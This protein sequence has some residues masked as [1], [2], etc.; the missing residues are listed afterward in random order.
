LDKGRT[1]V[2]MNE[3]SSYSLST[4]VTM[5]LAMQ[6]AFASAQKVAPAQT[7]VRHFH[8]AGLSLQINFVGT[9][10]AEKFTRSFVHLQVEAADAKAAALQI[11]LWDITASCVSEPSIDLA[12]AFPDR[13][14]FA[15]GELSAVDDSRYS[16]HCSRHST[17]LL[18]AESGR[19]A[20]FVQSAD[21]LSLYEVGKPLQPLLFAWYRRNGRQPVHA[22]C[23][24]RGSQGVLIGGAGGS[25]K[26]TTSLACTMA[27]FQFLADD[28]VA[29]AERGDE[30]IAYSLYA[31]LWLEDQH[32]RQFTSLSEH[33]MQVPWQTRLKIPFALG[34]AYPQQMVSSCV[35][36]ALVLPRVTPGE[37]S[38]LSRATP[39]EALLKMAP[40]SVVQLPFIDPVE[41]LRRMAELV[42]TVPAFWLDAGTDLA[43]IPD[44]LDEALR[45]AELERVKP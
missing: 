44:C 24:A 33:H 9:A 11:D 27:G 18:D 25:G 38:R 10:L 42:R 13:Q 26:S 20:G 32:S 2:E 39:R 35:V 22:A 41:S 16:M 19:A 43:S 34:D 40:S 23:V 14:P 29:L 30:H 8:I 36:R 3:R 5:L 21:D 37:R 4:P 6:A 17:T 28:Y 12:T 45:L 15:D 7:H 31:S 1:K